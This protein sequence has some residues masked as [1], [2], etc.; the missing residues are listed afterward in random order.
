MKAYYFGYVLESNKN[1][2]LAFFPSRM[3]STTAKFNDQLIRH[4]INMSPYVENN[5][6]T[7]E[8]ERKILITNCSH[9]R[10]A[11][12]INLQNYKQHIKSKVGNGRPTFPPSRLVLKH[13]KLSRIKTSQHV[14]VYNNLA[15]SFSP[16]IKNRTM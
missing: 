3:N 14:S 11:R 13:R 2:S 5:H 4:Q 9:P 15:E 1:I 16:L 10:D 12:R 6:A 8:S 7:N